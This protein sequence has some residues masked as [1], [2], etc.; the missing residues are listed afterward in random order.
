MVSFLEFFTE[1]PYLKVIVGVAVIVVVAVI[2]ERFMTRY[3][4]RFTKRRKLPPHV[5]NGM[6]L[7]S[8][9]LILLGVVIALFRVAGLPAEWFVAFSA[10]GGTAIGF[11]S[12]RTLG[13]F[14]AGFY[15]LLTQP[16]RVRDY[17]RIGVT[18]GIV[19]E[20]SLNYTKI[21]TPSNTTVLI[22]NQRV[23]DQ[24]I[25]N[26]RQKGSRPPL[27]CYSF[28]LGFSHALPIIQL[29]KTF[30]KVIEQYA[31]KLARK[32]EYAMTKI[33]HVARIYMFYLYVESPR[34]VFTLQPV[35]VRNITKACDEAITKKS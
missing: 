1:I 10:L 8:R 14:V 12:T 28:E 5:G 15:V 9:L 11:A 2:L 22:S 34:D 35:F 32:P 31:E 18:E 25:V 20:I 13:N 17:V 6:V 16:F 3:F 7:V 4:R 19:E 30:D 21:R 24:E 26:Y 33:S 29:E 23:L 27:Y